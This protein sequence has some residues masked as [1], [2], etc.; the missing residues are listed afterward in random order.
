L[1]KKEEK[2]KGKRKKQGSTGPN[3]SY[4]G[5]EMGSL[6]ESLGHVSIINV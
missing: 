6:P 4:P 1:E 3:G 5:P 2:K